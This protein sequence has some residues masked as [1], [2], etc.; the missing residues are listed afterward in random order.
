MIRKLII[1]NFRC[2][3]KSTITFNGSSVLV[4][5]NNAGKSTLI[6]AL[7]I[8][9]TITKRYRTARFVAP[10]DWVKSANT[11]G[12]SPNVENMNISDHGIFYLYG[13]PPAIIE[14]YFS[15]GSIIKAFV[16]EELSVFAL[17]FD[18]KG[19]P[20]E[21]NKKAKIVNIPLIEVLPQISAV[22]DTEKV[23]KKTTVDGNRS[24]H[25]ASRNFRNQLFYYSDAFPTFKALVEATWE[26]L[27][28][29]P[30]ESEFINDGQ[31]LS[32]Y[33]RVRS[34]EAELGWMGHGLQMW[35]QTMWFISQCP[36]DAIVVLDEP[37]VYMHADLQRRLV[38]LITPMFSQLIIATHSLEIIEEASSESIVP[39]DSNKRQIK[40]I[41]D[42]SVVSTLSEELGNPLNIDLAR[43]FISN[44][45]II[46]DGGNSD[47]V[48]LSAF[49][50]ILY[51]QDL[52]P[53]ITYPKAYVNGWDDWNKSIA[54]AEVFSINKMAVELFCISNSGYHT[55]EEI[56]ERNNDA[57]SRGINLHIWA[58]NEIDNYAININVICRYLEITSQK[59][60]IDRQL[61][62]KKTQEILSTIYKNIEK[63]IN[64]SGKEN[65]K[66]VIDEVNSR[67]D[68]PLNI[69][70]G[71]T[72]FKLLSVWT[73]KEYGVGISARRI[74]PY[75]FQNEVPKEIKT[76]IDLLIKGNRR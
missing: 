50:S 71:K 63:K 30:V 74:V 36:K 49:Q 7:K 31:F 54:I 55:L 3:E 76:I 32:F 52:H 69:I 23:L 56:Q 15:N 5:K 46:W 72:F 66:E 75:F 53:I 60:N 17:L 47:R 48:I 70:S 29:K 19:E 40:P 73:Y 51:P 13:S 42:E 39:I 37:D 2:Y 25:L 45:F 6:E 1:K 9:S 65:K 41:G 16:G 38:R 44:R 24:T 67:L 58:K 20:V 11:Y 68:E 22:L 34:F 14:S 61:V 4:G 10:P 64:N 21:S 28:V 62:I 27:Q 35:I 18:E 59:E 8:I 43:L 26:E 57:V 33:V 12:V